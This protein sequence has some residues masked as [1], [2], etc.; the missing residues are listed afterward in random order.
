CAVHRLDSHI[1]RFNWNWRGRSRVGLSD[2]SLGALPGWDYVD[3]AL[4][5]LQPDQC[6]LLEKPGW[7]DQEYR[8]PKTHADGA[9]LVPAWGH[10]DRAGGGLVV[11]PHVPQGR[12]RSGGFGN[13]WAARD[14][15]DG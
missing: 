15:H 3:R 11:W 7:A 8:D 2:P 5:F 1:F 6:R 4:V 12:N 14:H 9:Q 10:R 13:R